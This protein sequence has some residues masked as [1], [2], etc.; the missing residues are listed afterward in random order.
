MTH[1]TPEF[2]DRNQFCSEKCE[3]CMRLDREELDAGLTHEEV[4]NRALNLA[5]AA[6]EREQE[7]D[8]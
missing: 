1:A 7:T 3:E 8:A 5:L 2:F 4:I 6:V